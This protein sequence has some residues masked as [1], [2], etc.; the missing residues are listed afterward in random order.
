MHM[1]VT[2]STLILTMNFDLSRVMDMILGEG[3]QSVEKLK[4]NNDDEIMLKL[5]YFHS[6][7][8]LSFATFFSQ[9]VMVISL[10]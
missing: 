2:S 6:L 5:P 8:Q 7:Y 3:R 4:K 9:P 10:I 1:M